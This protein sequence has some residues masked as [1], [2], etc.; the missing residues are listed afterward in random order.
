MKRFVTVFV[1]LAF[2]FGMGFWNAISPD[3][4]FSELEN[5]YLTEF[6][7]FSWE[8]LFEG[9]WMGEFEEY[10]NDQF[11]LR[12]GWI[13][14]KSY[15]ERLTGKQENNGVYLLGDTLIEKFSRYDEERLQ[16]NIKA[17][18][19]FAGQ[20]ELPVCL[21][22]IP[23]SACTWKEKLPAGAPNADQ[24]AIIE[25]VYEGA[26]TNC[27]D[28]AGTLAAHADEDIYYRTD[29]HWT[30]KGA[31][32]GYATIVQAM[33]LVPSSP[34]EYT[35]EKVSDSFYGTL[36]SN[37]GA[38]Y[39]EPDEMW[40]WAPEKDVVALHYEN[41]QMTEGSVYQRRFLQEKDK[42]KA[43]TGGNQPLVVLKGKQ[44][45]KPRLMIVRDSYTDSMALFFMEHFSEVHLVDLRYYRQSVLA[46]AQEN[47]IDQVLIVYGVKNF[48]EDGNLY[49]LPRA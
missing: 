35:P 28:I 45:E 6:P 33:G 16:K 40:F 19:D 1:F 30:A 39:L 42:Y 36:F 29:H 22:L 15:A 21:A 2:L 25:A 8:S 34:D 41:G 14:V 31:Y 4:S 3:R 26:Q 43:Y 37:S 5:R 10:L 46:Y 48:A 49:M 24:K 38:R 7:D 27:A 47:Q 12:D 17:V 9:E 44:E 13:A 23:T 18:A 20:T 32:Y 11:P